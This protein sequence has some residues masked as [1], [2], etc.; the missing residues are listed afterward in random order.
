MTNAIPLIALLLCVQLVA[1]FEYV[2]EQERRAA[3]ILVAQESAAPI[4]GVEIRRTS[5]AGQLQVVI[6]NLGSHYVEEDWSRSAL[7]DG[8]GLVRS[9]TPRRPYTVSVIPPQARLEAPIV[10]AQGELAGALAL[11]GP[12]SAGE[13]LEVTMAFTIA[14]TP[15]FTRSASS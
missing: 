7:A 11:A 8:D 5:Q 6:R 14:G 9:I 3:T 12:E 10:S 4:A 2:T 13:S 1:A 15:R